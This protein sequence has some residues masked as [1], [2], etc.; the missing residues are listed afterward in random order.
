MRW[1]ICRVIRRPILR[2]HRTQEP[3]CKRDHTS[4]LALVA[5]NRGFDSLKI[6]YYCWYNTWLY[7]LLLIFLRCNQGTQPGTRPEPQSQFNL[8]LTYLPA[9]NSNSSPRLRTTY[10]NSAPNSTAQHSIAQCNL[11]RNH[12]VP[13]P[14]RQSDSSRERPSS[15]SRLDQSLDQSQVKSHKIFYGLST[16]LPFHSIT[17]SLKSSKLSL[18]CNVRRYHALWYYTIHDTKSHLTA[19]L[20]QTA[21]CASQTRRESV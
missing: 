16:S 5:S 9:S 21:R 7:M 3:K 2:P 13:I 8:S 6:M 20:V 10:T 19:S 17:P 11:H 15:V 1:E 18:S 4:N 14:P 12:N